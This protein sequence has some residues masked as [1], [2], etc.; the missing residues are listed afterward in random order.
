MPQEIHYSDVLV[1]SDDSPTLVVVA[2]SRHCPAGLY[3]VAADIVDML[4][5]VASLK[6]KRARFA[7]LAHR[8][9]QVVPLLREAGWTTDSIYTEGAPGLYEF[10]MAGSALDLRSMARLESEMRLHSAVEYG[11]QILWKKVRTSWLPACDVNTHHD[12]E[13]DHV[14][15]ILL[16]IPIEAL[17]REPAAVRCDLVARMFRELFVRF[18]TI[19]GFIDIC[20]HGDA[21]GGAVHYGDRSASPV[22]WS[23]YCDQILWR[24]GRQKGLL[25]PVRPY[26]GNFFGRELLT[27]IDVADVLREF[28]KPT[29]PAY[30][31]DWGRAEVIEDGNL[32]IMLSA[33]P[34]HVVNT[35]RSSVDEVFAHTVPL[36]TDLLP[37]LKEA[38]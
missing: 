16:S 37:R 29:H 2:Y 28:S 3:S 31:E 17:S 18:G 13:D 32:A 4:S 1:D 25:N 26:W 23:R 9:D 38:T 19:Y 7:A 12:S 34:L 24:R 27:E 21:A 36:M 30:T 10:A 14:S 22:G 5:P 20:G 35:V 6:V 33:D 15:Q 11:V 8:N